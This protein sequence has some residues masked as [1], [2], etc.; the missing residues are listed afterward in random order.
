M[1][2]V[3]VEERGKAIILEYGYFGRKAT[4]RHF[5]Y[6]ANAE[7]T[8]RTGHAAHAGNAAHAVLTGNLLVVVFRRLGHELESAAVR[9]LAHLAH[10]IKDVVSHESQVLC[11]MRSEGGGG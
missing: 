7:N 2:G 3:Y 8:G 1:H 11:A 4:Y 9:A 10:G 5:L 6:N